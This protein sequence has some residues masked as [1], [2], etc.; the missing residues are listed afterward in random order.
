[1]GLMPTLELMESNY[2]GKDLRV[3]DSVREG[4]T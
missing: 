3:T 4:V 2:Q 1:M